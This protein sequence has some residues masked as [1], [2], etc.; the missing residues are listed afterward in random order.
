[1]FKDSHQALGELLYR[2]G[3]IPE[4]VDVRYEAPTKQ[5]VDSLIRPTISFFLFDVQE[6]KEKRETNLQTFR[7]N[8]G[9]E[10]R[11]PPRRIDL[12]YCVSAF[13]TD[14]ADEHELLWRVLATLMK[15]EQFPE[16]V[17]TD[18]LRRADPPLSARMAGNET[19]N[20]L[21][22]LWSSLGIPPHAA[23]CYILTAPMD[24]DFS[25]QAPLVLTR[26]SRYKSTVSDA[27]YEATLQIGG[28]VR[29]KS[30]SPLDGFT[31]RRRGT[32]YEGSVTNLEGQFRLRG[33]PRGRLRLDVLKEGKLRKQVEIE[34]P[35]ESYEIVL[36]E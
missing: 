4:E 23:L 21:A 12:M 33:V 35:A 2:R 24:L 26:M 34:V 25:I 3:M 29:G 17:L 7:G 14:V 27:T 9:V 15:Y 32:A 28:V 31:V 18:G 19:S 16:D 13:A 8:G 11:M 22:E 6:N 36:D 5:W 30:G 20:R 10:R 1:M